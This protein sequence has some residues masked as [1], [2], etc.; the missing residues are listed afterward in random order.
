MLSPGVTVREWDLT[1]IIP[2]V[3][4]AGAAYVGSFQWGP[5][6]KMKTVA[7]E[8]YLVNLFGRPDDDTFIHFYSCKNFLDYSRNLKVIRVVEDTAKNATV[9]GDGIL[10]KNESDWLENHSAGGNEEGEFCGRYPGSLGN[11][12]RIEMADRV[13]Y[14]AVSD[15]TVVNPGSGYTTVDDNGAAVTFSAPPAGGTTATGTLV[16]VDDV[17][18]GVNITDNGSGYV[19]PPTITIDPPSAGGIDD[20]TAVI[21]ASLWKY[22]DQFLSAPGTSDYVADRGGADDEMHIIILDD[23]GAITGEA[24][25]VLERW[26]YVS[27]ASDAKYD[28]GTSAYYV[29]VLRDRSFYVHWLD[30]YDPQLAG[31]WGS[32]ANGVTGTGTSFSLMDAPYSAK[33][34][35][36]VDGNDVSNDE[37]IP[38]WDQ[39]KNP[40]NVDIGFLIAGDADQILMEYLIQNIAEWR[41]DC[42]AVISPDMND[43]VNNP[44]S[45]LSDVLG[46]RNVLT[47]SS[48]GIMDCN[49]KYQFDVYNNTFRWV[50]CN[51]DVAGLMARTDENRDPWWSPGGYN[52]GKI[53]NVVKLAWNPNRTERD[54]LY[55]NGINPI[56]SEKNEGTLMLGDKT[57]LA[58]PSAFDRINVRRLFIVLEK[59]I[60]KAAKYA[61]FE[62]NDPF[63]RARFSQIVE[64]YLRDVQGRRGIQPDSNIGPGFKVICDETNNTPFVIDN[65][66][67]V[68]DIYIKPNRSINFITLNFIATPTGVT[69]EEVQGA[70]GDF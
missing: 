61:L 4:T 63:T 1:T 16:V 8:E 14:T 62:F 50:P 25:T 40:E 17:V 13:G 42:V 35:G 22:K 51:A 6:D 32:T 15:V 10:V 58:K 47:S 27:K 34:A 43:V 64:P 31:D 44:T 60:A 69:F 24:G 52:R 30:H 23:T 29:N 38:G 39:F 12:I 66:A 3:A 20:E 18:T 70:F 41:K 59:A 21:T 7:S 68:G 48:Y 53:K 26:K 49:W 65:N 67:F 9:D 56:I 45:E 57:M 46:L 2:Q 11:N 36:G 19:I 54:E 5:V 28:D 37:L 55:Q 33:L